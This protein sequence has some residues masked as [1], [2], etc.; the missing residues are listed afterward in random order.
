MGDDEESSQ[1]PAK[2]KDYSEVHPSE[3]PPSW[4]LV[5]RGGLCGGITTRIE[6]SAQQV[7]RT[8]LDIDSEQS[9]Y[10]FN[11]EVSDIDRRDKSAKGSHIKLG[12]YWTEM[13]LHPKW[14]WKKFHS[15][16]VEMKNDDETNQSFDS[17]RSISHA[18]SLHDTDSVH[19]TSISRYT[20]T[21]HKVDG[22]QQD[23]ACMLSVSFAMVPGNVISKIAVLILGKVVI[24][25]M[26]YTMRKQLLALALAAETYE[27]AGKDQTVETEEKNDVT[28]D[29]IVSAAKKYTKD[30]AENA[31]DDIAGETYTKKDLQKFVSNN[32]LQ[33]NSDEGIASYA[34]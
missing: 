24:K 28:N 4:Q 27:A 5:Q 15:W 22:E 21:L 26:L 16:I 14:G 6:A 32:A 17:P 20:Y 9:R 2:G 11:P 12:S 1:K 7:W 31:L 18:M 10:T 19:Q 13:H 29:I 25:R 33:N 30:D 23:N 3:L 34:F 8:I